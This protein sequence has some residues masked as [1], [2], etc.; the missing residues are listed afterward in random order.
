MK[1]SY[2]IVLIVVIIVVFYFF[3]QQAKAAAINT[4]K[5][6]AINTGS[7]SYSAGLALA[8]LIGSTKCGKNGNPPC[9][10]TDLHNA[11]WSPD[12]ISSA[13]QGSGT[14][15]NFFLCQNFGVNC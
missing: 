4:T 9:T 8:S 1:T 5:D 7:A 11:G 3:N 14:V 10:I 15:K 2:W 6:N 12:Q 13:E